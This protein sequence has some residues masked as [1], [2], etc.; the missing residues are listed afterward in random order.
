MISLFYLA[1]FI[2]FFYEQSQLSL[3]KK[4]KRKKG[5]IRNK[6]PK[7]HVLRKNAFAQPAG[8]SVERLSLLIILGEIIA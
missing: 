3:G 2:S 6:F 7:D 4:K 5:L 8:E 1:H